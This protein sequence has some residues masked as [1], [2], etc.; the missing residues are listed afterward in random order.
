M[1][2]N[3]IKETKKGFNISDR[4]RKRDDK[5]KEGHFSLKEERFINLGE[6]IVFSKPLQDPS[7]H[8]RHQALRIERRKRI[9]GRLETKVGSKCR[10]PYIVLGYSKKVVCVSKIE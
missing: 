5:A 2:K 9:A 4:L 7:P 10:L 3:E 1:S 8:R 6:K